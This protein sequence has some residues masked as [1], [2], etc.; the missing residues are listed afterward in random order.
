MR[1]LKMSWHRQG[2]HLVCRWIEQKEK[3]APFS[4]ADM[5]GS[6]MAQFAVVPFGASGPY[7]SR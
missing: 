3:S 2:G 4:A 7:R 5:R 1:R 6:T